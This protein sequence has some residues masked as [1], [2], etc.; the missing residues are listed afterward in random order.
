MESQ[1]R[2]ECKRAIGSGKGVE[3][4]QGSG[5]IDRRADRRYEMDSIGRRILEVGVVR[6]ASGVAWRCRFEREN[7][8]FRA[9]SHMFRIYDQKHIL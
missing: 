5:Q 1:W 9:L 3:I 2:T 7:A 8:R 6:A 4:G